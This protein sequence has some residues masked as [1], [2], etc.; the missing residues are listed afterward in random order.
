MTL[1]SGDRNTKG[2][3]LLVRIGVP[4]DCISGVAVGDADADGIIPSPAKAA[5]PISTTFP[6]D[7]TL[8]GA[9]NSRFFSNFGTFGILVYPSESIC[10]IRDRNKGKI[11]R[12]DTRWLTLADLLKNQVGPLSAY[13]FAYAGR[14]RKTWQ[15]AYSAISLYSCFGL[16]LLPGGRPRLLIRDIQAGGR[17]RRRPR[18]AAKRSSVMIASSICS[19]STR[20]SA[21]IFVMSIFGVYCRSENG[22]SQEGSGSTAGEQTANPL[23]HD[24]N[25]ARP[26]LPRLLSRS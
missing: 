26:F 5:P 24:S 12:L 11:N 15:K 21:N 18:P 16:F 20:S 23:C 9:S 6:S 7:P 14:R 19:R 10:E 2:A 8:F 22:W 1:F 13:G 4:A 3:A 17:P 25:R